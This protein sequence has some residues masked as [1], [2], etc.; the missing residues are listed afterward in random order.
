MIKLCMIQLVAVGFV[1]IG[2]LNMFASFFGVTMMPLGVSL[3]LIGGGILVVILM[4]KI[5][6]KHL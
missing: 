1:I 5:N 3:F 4:E 2:L 6:S